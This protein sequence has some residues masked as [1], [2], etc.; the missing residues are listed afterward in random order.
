MT[1][2]RL[3]WVY[4]ETVGFKN[5]QGN[6]MP[7]WVDLPDPIKLAWE[8]CAA[9]KDADIVVLDAREK[10]Q[11]QHARFYAANYAEAGVP[12]HG[13]FILIAKLAKA[14]GL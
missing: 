10:Q 14:L 6:P 8:R 11:V 9:A 4:G 12:G 1:G 3:Y 13:Q 7:A 2:E 5:Y